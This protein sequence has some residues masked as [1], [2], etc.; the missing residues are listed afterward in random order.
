[1]LQRSRQWLCCVIDTRSV[2]RRDVHLPI[3][4]VLSIRS[5]PSC[6]PRFSYGET[7]LLLLQ[8]TRITAGKFISRSTL[9]CLA[10]C[11]VC[12]SSQRRSRLCDYVLGLALATGAFAK[13][14]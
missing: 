1:M 6:P 5:E 14:E 11:A 9:M 3:S 13:K 4:R 7:L 2:N 8:L 10:L 12:K